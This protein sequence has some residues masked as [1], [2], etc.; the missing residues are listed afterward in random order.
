MPETISGTAFMPNYP[1]TDVSEQAK[2]ALEKGTKMIEEFN[3]FAKGNV[4]AVV[5]AGRAA[6][7][8]AETLSQTAAEYS[9]KIFDEAT[10]AMN[11]LSGANSPTEFFKR[12]NDCA[13]TQLSS[14]TAEA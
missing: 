6:A 9:R 5:A 14:M 4:E 2:S 8:G 11:A 13:K 10:T 3:D 7:K 12:Q 1:F